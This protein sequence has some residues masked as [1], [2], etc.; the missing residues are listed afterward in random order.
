MFIT[1]MG[2]TAQAQLPLTHNYRVGTG[3]QSF[4][5]LLP[6]DLVSNS[7]SQIQT[8]LCLKGYFPCK[9][10]PHGCSTY[11]GQFFSAQM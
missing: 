4:D 7:G 1:T 6:T 8:Y 9:H 11:S 5:S 3:T 10:V 2:H